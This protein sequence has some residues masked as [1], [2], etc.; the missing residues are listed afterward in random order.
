MLV[1]DKL[2]LCCGIV[3]DYPDFIHMVTWGSL[4]DKGKRQ[5]WNDNKCNDVV[6]G[7]SKKNCEIKGI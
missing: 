5:Y 7:S 1:E 3:K 2:A 4:N 6:G